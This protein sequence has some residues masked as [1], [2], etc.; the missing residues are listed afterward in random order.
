MTLMIDLPVD[1]ET[2]LERTARALGLDTTGYARQIIEASLPLEP[3]RALADL[4]TAWI[5]ED[6]TDDPEELESREAEWQELKA[7]LNANRAI[8]GQRILFP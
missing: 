7:N 6:A 4:M 3:N 5:Q 1:V 8:G 2:R